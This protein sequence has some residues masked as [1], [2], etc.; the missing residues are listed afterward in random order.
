MNTKQHAIAILK[1]LFIALI[2]WLALI[3][4]T[5]CSTQ[6]GNI[7]EEVK[8]EGRINEIILVPI[9]LARFL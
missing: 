8:L 4:A 5:S 2:I 7:R 6:N 1:L 9:G 3:V